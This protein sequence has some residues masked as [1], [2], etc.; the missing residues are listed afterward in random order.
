LS[1]GSWGRDWVA[2]AEKLL[3]SLRDIAGVGITLSEDGREIT[4]I[5]ILAEG[6]R[7]PKQIVRDVRSALRA[8]F[9]VDVDYRKISVAQKRE[10]SLEAVPEPATRS[11]PTVLTLPAGRVDEEPAAIRLRFVG[12]TVGIDQSTCR[13]RVELCLGDREA[14]GDASGANSRRQVPR[15]IAEATLS[16]ISRFLDD[17]YVLSLI[18]LEVLEFGGE[19]VVLVAIKFFKDR[20][21]KTL[22]GSCVVSHDLQQ[23][24]V[25]GTLDSLNRTLGRL[26]YRETVEYEIRPTTMS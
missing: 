2:Q 22:T 23:S 13:A 11:L 7:P 1:D 9:Q 4:E 6:Q 14:V 3:L 18:D 21:E 20:I 15:L 25:Y 5:S 8:E 16:A 17:S 26:R 24:V 12:V 19:E 10:S